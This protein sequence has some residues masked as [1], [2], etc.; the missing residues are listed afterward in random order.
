MY[1][2]ANML[3]SQLYKPY[4]VDGV[5]WMLTREIHQR[6]PG[7]FL[8]DEM[9]LGKTIQTVATMIYNRLPRTLV[10]VPT[11]L[12]HQWISEIR[13]H[14]TLSVSVFDGTSD[15]DVCVTTYGSFLKK[16]K[17]YDSVMSTHWNRVVLDEAHDIR[18]PKSKRFSSILRLKCDIR[19]ILTGTP[20]YNSKKD[21]NTL[22][23]FLANDF[24]FTEDRKSVILRRT[25]A[26][27]AGF[28][29]NLRLP[30]CDFEYLEFERYPE[31]EEGYIQVFTDFSERIKDAEDNES[32]MVI[33]EG[34]LRMR[35]YSIHP[36][37]FHSGVNME[38]YQ[39]RSR[40]LELLNELISSHPDE[41]TLVFC[42][43]K[44]EM[45]MIGKLVNQKV[46]RLDGDVDPYS[47][48]S[49]INEFKTHVGGCVFLIQ[50][51]TGGQG[52]NLQEASR[53]YITTP[54]W[55]PA[56]ELQAIAR[57]HRNGQTKSVV[58]RKLVYVSSSD[59]PSIEEAIVDLQNHKSTVCSD[60]LNDPRINEQ[61]PK[62]K[63]KNNMVTIF[64]RFFT[65]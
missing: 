12:V 36:Q 22:L 38:P 48:E 61:L 15:A 51:K 13:T 3:K 8:C 28:N 53:V 45:T 17:M 41:K 46:F 58:V 10:V 4:Q 63:R 65:C 16:S 37:L 20:V 32:A 50:I 33:L 21:F 27:L 11:S 23:R 1:Q 19:W 54:A 6:F 2:K 60:V 35:Q 40:K 18:N 43:F 29:E 39:G 55:N 31:E 14:S 25:K 34:F 56:T 24:F 30:P 5:K 42:Q 59:T 47:R 7:G 52:L 62:M 9:G 64:R 44:Q 57:S 26:D 49:L